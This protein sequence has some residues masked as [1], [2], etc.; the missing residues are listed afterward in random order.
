MEESNISIE[1]LPIVRQLKSGECVMSG[2]TKKY[3][4]LVKQ[5]NTELIVI[6]AIDYEDAVKIAEKEV[7]MHCTGH[8]DQ[9]YEKKGGNF[10]TFTSWTQM[11]F[12]H[13]QVGLR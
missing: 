7:R 13:L 9:V 2:E 6:D 4:V 12:L 8:G 10:L 11:N 3:G 1:N 5:E